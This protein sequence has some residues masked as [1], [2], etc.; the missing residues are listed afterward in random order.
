MANTSILKGRLRQR[1]LHSDSR[2]SAFK[3]ELFGHA[4]ERTSGRQKSLEL[5][6]GTVTA[7]LDACISIQVTVHV[8]QAKI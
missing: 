3:I 8:S 6:M 1:L 5:I 4:M 2:R 7:V